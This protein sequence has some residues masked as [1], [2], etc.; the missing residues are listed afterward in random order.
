MWLRRSIYFYKQHLIEVRKVNKLKR[1]MIVYKIKIFL[2]KN[3]MPYSKE[4]SA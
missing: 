2:I 1:M 4:A 3:K